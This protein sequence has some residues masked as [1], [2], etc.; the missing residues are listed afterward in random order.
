VI[1]RTAYAMGTCLLFLA[2]AWGL[3]PITDEEFALWPR[4]VSRSDLN[5]EG[6]MIFRSRDN[7]NAV[8][9][10]LAVSFKASR[11][12]ELGAGLKT[13]WGDGSDAV[14][15]IP[16]GLKYQANAATTLNLDFLIGTHGDDDGLRLG[17]LSR[18]QHTSRLSS[19]LSG[20][21]GFFNAYT[22]DGKSVALEGA[23]LPSLRL[24]RDIS[25][26]SGFVA[27]SQTADFNDHFAFDWQP[28]LFVDLGR[29]GGVLTQV[30]LGLAGDA[31]E[32]I[33]VKVALS[34]GF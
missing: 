8:E 4:S 21:I 5:V 20:Q 26:E 27:S 10:P 19:Q 30:T 3:N 29:D 34:Q 7:G 12:L 1:K 9:I 14:P 23:W 33:R 11:S 15:F 22:G 16:L 25:V 6:G 31:R 28:G 24:L 18:V 2:Q 17:V 32:D 13:D